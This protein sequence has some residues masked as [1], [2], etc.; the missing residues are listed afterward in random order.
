MTLTAEQT[1]DQVG[2]QYEDVY[3]NN[4]GLK[5]FINSSLGMLQP[6]STVLDVG[7]GTG[8]PVADQLARAGHEVHGIDVSQKMIEVAQNQVKGRFTKVD[9]T[10]F[11]PETKFDAIY[12][13]YS[14]FQLTDNEIYKMLF[15][16]SD[17]LKPGGLL[18]FGIVPSTSLVKDPRD[19]DASGQVARHYET[20][21]MQQR[22]TY[23]LYTKEKW[24][25]LIRSAG[26]E[27]QLEQSCTLQVDSPNETYDQYLIIA[28]KQV[29][30]ALT[31]PFPLPASYRGPHFL[32]E[33]AWGPLS[34]CLVRSEFEAVMEILQNNHRI[35]D[36][37]KLPTEL[38]QRGA[39]AFSIEPNPDRHA[40]QLQRSANGTVEIRKGS[41]ENL[42][43]DSEFVDAAVAMWVLHYVDDLEK[44][45]HE[46]ARVVDRSNPNARIVLVQGAP[47]NELVR[48][49]NDVCAPLSAGNTLLDHQGY[50]LHRA[51]EVFT[52]CGFADIT[53]T[54]ADAFCVFPEED[55]E[56]RCRRAADVL[57]GCWY[58]EDANYEL[59]KE[60]LI[61]HLRLHF[62][63]RPHAVGD[64]AVILVA[65][66]HQN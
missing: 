1:F 43:F 18:V 35:L 25:E 5:K 40:M 55:L 17:W 26:F 65:R 29:T 36:I 50:L 54:R 49:L 59:M 28:R 30:H 15:Q 47:N 31:G 41:A 46:M 53:L 20:E 44:S 32:C 23:T 24:A 3:R 27:I 51:V 9:M 60:A 34:Q 39:Q 21:F 62:R 12:T 8:K 61:P 22:V 42:P 33:A 45:L 10:S 63:D 64:E 7:C 48:L 2:K 16:F 58:L 11:E 13:V 14:L 56:E 66:P 6:G 57:V 38:A 4:P 19:Y 37:G 52:S